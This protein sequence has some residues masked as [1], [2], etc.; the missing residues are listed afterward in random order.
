MTRGFKECVGYIYTADHFEQHYQ[1]NRVVA[2]HTT[3]NMQPLK[4]IYTVNMRL[5]IKMESHKGFVVFIFNQIT[6]ADA[7]HLQ[8]DIVNIVGFIQCVREMHWLNLNI[9]YIT[10]LVC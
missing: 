7:I 4:Q 9:S 1:N 3:Q 10:K 8:V 6:Q 5:S 2:P